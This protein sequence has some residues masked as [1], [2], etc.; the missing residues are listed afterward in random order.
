MSGYE[1]SSITEV[2]TIVDTADTAE[3]VYHET[4]PYSAR[5][6]AAVAASR[7]FT[8]G[9]INEPLQIEVSDPAETALTIQLPTDAGDE[10]AV[11]FAMIDENGIPIVRFFADGGAVFNAVQWGGEFLCQLAANRDFKVFTDGSPALLVG[12]DGLTRLKPIVTQTSAPDDSALASGQVALWFDQTD[13][14]AKLKI[15]GKSADGTVV[16]GEVALA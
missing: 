4:L 2:E 14:A 1:A 6:V 16:S 12:G 8:G 7:G 5:A 13:G 10:D 11:Q 3:E 15:K 9:T